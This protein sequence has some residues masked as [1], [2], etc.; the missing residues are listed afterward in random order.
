[1][2]KQWNKQMESAIKTSEETRTRRNENKKK[3]KQ[4]E[5]KTWKMKTWRNEKP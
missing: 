5:M 2:K 1:M 3:Q 4:E